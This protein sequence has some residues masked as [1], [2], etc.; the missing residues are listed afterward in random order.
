MAESSDSIAPRIAIVN[1]E[2][3][4]SRIIARRF[5]LSLRSISG[6]LG[7]GIDVGSSYKS[8]IVVMFATSVNLSNSQTRKVTTMMETREPGIFF[9]IFGLYRMMRRLITPTPRAH[10]L[11]CVTFWK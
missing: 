9:E 6:S 3:N 5:C 2:G 8:P 11:T 7:A 4:R 1:A 10:Q